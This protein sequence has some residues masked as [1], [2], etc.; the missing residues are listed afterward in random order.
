MKKTNNPLSN[1]E[2]TRLLRTAQSVIGRS[3]IALQRELPIMKIKKPDSNI[4]FINN[5]R[6]SIV[7]ITNI[8]DVCDI[9]VVHFC[10]PLDT[11]RCRNI[12]NDTMEILKPNIW[13]DE[14]TIVQCN[15]EI[16]GESKFIVGW[17]YSSLLR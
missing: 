14:D 1:T 13:V 6:C 16:S 15:T 17:R 9:S 8:F 10:H 5:E 7:C 2:V 3:A 4:F 11:E 12:C